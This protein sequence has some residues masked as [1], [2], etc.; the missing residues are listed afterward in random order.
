MSTYMIT[1]V[2]NANANVDRITWM[3]RPVGGRNIEFPH[4][5]DHMRRGKKR[6]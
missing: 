2:E 3:I 1:H 4:M 6:M 5:D